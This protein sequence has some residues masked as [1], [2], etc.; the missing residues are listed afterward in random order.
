M[1]IHALSIPLYGIYLL[2]LLDLLLCH[3]HPLSIP[4]YGIRVQV[5]RGLPQA[6]TDSFYSLIWD[7]PHG[8]TQHPDEDRHVLSIPLYGIVRS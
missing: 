7:R 4:L 5:R 6:V 1:S 3:V 2:N 8:S